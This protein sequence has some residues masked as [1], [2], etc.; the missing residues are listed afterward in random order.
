MRTVVIIITSLVQMEIVIMAARSVRIVMPGAILIIL[1][2][3]VE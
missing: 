1:T 3:I 2:M